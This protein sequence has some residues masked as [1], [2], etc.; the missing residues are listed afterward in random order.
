MNLNDCMR[1]ARDELLATGETVTIQALI[2]TALDL[3]GARTEFEEQAQ[4]RAMATLKR[5]ARQ[6]LNE[7]TEMVADTTDSGQGHL[8][9]LLPGEPAP[10]AIS[11]EVDGDVAYKAYGA[12]TDRELAANLKILDSNITHAITKRRDRSDKRDA[13]APFRADENTT[14]VEALQA[15]ERKQAADAA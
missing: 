13:L 10:S 1:Q 2:D 5:E 15:M 7:A 11:L 3:N 6:L 4:R 14:T 9:A 8:F 12:S